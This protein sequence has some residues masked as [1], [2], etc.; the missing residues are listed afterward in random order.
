[1]IRALNNKNNRSGD[2]IKGLTQDEAKKLLEQYGPNELI[3]GEKTSAVALFFNQFKDFI[4]AVL[5]IATV[6][7]FILGE[8]VDAIAIFI[9]IIINAILG[10]V[11]E[12]RTEKSLEALKEM[13]APH[14]KVV[15][16]GKQMDIPARELVPGDIVVLEAGVIIPADGMLIEGVNVQA[17]ESILTGE[18]VPVDKMANVKGKSDLYMGTV[19]TSG[20][21]YGLITSTGMQTEMGHIANMLESVEKEITPLQQ[22]LQKIGKQLVIISLIMCG[23]IVLAGILHGETVHKMIL[24]GISLAV[25]AIPE[26]LPAVVTVSLA[27][28]VQRMLKRNALIRKLPVVETLG[29]TDIICSDK[30]GTLTENKM[31]VKKIYIDDSTIDVTGIGH[32][33]SGSF[34]DKD[35]LDIDIKR[36][37]SL[38]MLLNVG[39]ICNNAKYEDGIVSGDPT[40]TAILIASKKGNIYESA[41][42]KFF[43]VHEFPFDSNRKRMS[44]ICRDRKGGIYLFVK[45]APDKII[46]LCKQRMHKGSEKNLTYMDKKRIMHV[47]EM[48]A[49]DA[50]RVL[51]FAYK[52]LDII[53]KRPNP[54]ML[55]KDLVF[56]GLE[57]MIDPPRP[58][59][60]EA[61]KDCYKAGI[62]PVMIT[63]DHKITAM[64]VARELNF[65]MQNQGVLTGDDIEAMDDDKLMEKIE[66]VSVFARV[67]PKHKL[68]IVQAFKRKG[69]IVA[70]TG[71]GVNDAPALKEAN[72]GIAMGKMGTDVAKEASSMILLDDNFATIVAAVKE[73]RIIYDNIRKFI[74]YLLACNLGEMILMGIAA[75]FAMP[76]PLVPIQILWINLVTDGLPALALG[77]DP[78]D[79]DIMKRLPRESQESIFSR[80]LGLEILL[81]GL[82]IG[83]SCLACFML[84]LNLTSGDIEKAQTMAFATIIVAELLYAFESRS[85]YKNAYEAGFFENKYLVLST[86]ISFLLMIVVIYN[87]FLSS[88][89]KTEPLNWADWFLVMG[90]SMVGFVINSVR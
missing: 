60:I 51:A 81:S 30:T 75:F 38:N 13:S 54:D 59:A 16:D 28:G 50:L 17:D 22:R 82:L 69:H 3:K 90:F 77:V 66:E 32:E 5:L 79:D 65:Q 37:P 10:F 52:R 49:N 61:I 57:G 21:G 14:A 42:A 44:V 15:R 78:P 80:G 9:I 23:L 26:G 36:C 64:A 87:P 85:E 20:R 68:R 7:S 19:L 6:V 8:K 74:R 45:G 83:I 67:K 73:G 48:M 46:D 11:Q 47:N 58:E 72:I 35:G 25:A 33:T 70:M 84:S 1:M 4:V 56:L 34:V 39:A 24:S 55:E 2:F 43:R 86:I 88:I 71:D 31:T 62:R 89:L 63:G 27:I 41:V 40:E 12:Y 76:I 29:C 18:S 53:P